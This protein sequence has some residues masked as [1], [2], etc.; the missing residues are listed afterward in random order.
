MIFLGLRFVNKRTIG[1]CALAGILV[2]GV[3]QLTFDIYGTVVNLTGHEST[4]QGRGHLWETL[5][6]TDTNPL[7]GA[8]FESYWLGER[9]EKIWSMPEF[10]WQPNQ[11]HNGYLELYLNLGIVGLLILAGVIFATFWKIRLELLENFEW[12][13]FQMGCLLAILAHNWTEA[14]FKGLSFPLLVFFIVAIN[15]PQL[16]AGSVAP[17]FEATCLEDETELVYSEGGVR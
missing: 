7:F 6:E 13:R 8:G 9:V 2:F 14:G 11:A 12:G 3:A 10:W 17:S 16:G 15:Y 4:I 1:L 5:L